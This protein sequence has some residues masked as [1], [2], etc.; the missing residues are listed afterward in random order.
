MSRK[1]LGLGTALAVLGLIIFAGA[2]TACGWDFMALS[3]V[4][5]VDNEYEITDDFRDIVINA[6]T[7]DIF[8]MPSGDG[9]CRVECHENE[10][11]RHSVKAEGGELKIDVEDNR[12]WYEFIGVDFVGPQIRIYV[13]ENE[14]GKISA[15]MSTGDVRIENLRTGDVEINVSTGDVILKNII[16][17]NEIR[18]DASTGDVNFDGCDAGGIYVNVSTGDVTGSL[19]SPKIF[20]ADSSTGAVEVPGTSEGGIC[21]INTSTGDIEIDIE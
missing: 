16:A 11:A 20:M 1:L 5:Y 13:P 18:I 8:I 17:E 3:T 9:G 15:D 12:K 21:E 10:N 19:L 6:D 4:E 7:A 14:Y 2:M